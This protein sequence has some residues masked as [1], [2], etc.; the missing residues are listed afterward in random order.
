MSKHG[1][2]SFI[3]TLAI[4]GGLLLSACSGKDNGTPAPTQATSAAAGAG[5]P[6]SAA[7]LPVAYVPEPLGSI[8]ATCNV[9]EL[10]KAPFESAPIKAALSET[11]SISG[12]VAAPQ[13]TNPS[14]WLHLDDKVQGHYFKVRLSPSIKRPD[15]A[16][17]TI[18][19]PPLTADSGFM[20]T[21]SVS[22]VP[23]GTYH[24][25]VVARVDGQSNICDDGR[26]VDFK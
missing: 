2:L 19:K 17:S 26:L 8:F 6:T 13:L 12:W 15:V 14:F 9:E 16:A 1:R 21:L 3:P 22:T 4:V 24:L 11:H 5:T 7:M 18:S 20:I 25:Y 23:V 10:D